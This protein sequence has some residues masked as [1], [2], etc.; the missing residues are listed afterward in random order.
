MLNFE[1]Q[2]QNR[3]RRHFDIRY[4]LFDILRLKRSFKAH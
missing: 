1:P 2:K 4:Y 3:Y